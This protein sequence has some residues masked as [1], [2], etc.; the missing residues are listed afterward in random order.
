MI[1]NEIVRE[2]IGFSYIGQGNFAYQSCV[3]PV[4]CM[5]RVSLDSKLILNAKSWKTHSKIFHKIYSP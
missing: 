2:N 4:F 5:Q 1:Y 3:N